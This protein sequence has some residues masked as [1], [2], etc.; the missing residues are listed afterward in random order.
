MQ[1]PT[2]PFA[3]KGSHAIAG[4]LVFVTVGLAMGTSLWG[5]LSLVSFFAVGAA[6]LRRVDIGAG[7]KRTR[8]EDS[9]MG[10]DGS[11]PSPTA[12]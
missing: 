10:T 5:V 3:E 8:E 12:A 6:L 11:A 7:Q 9:R 1:R 2:Q 4:P